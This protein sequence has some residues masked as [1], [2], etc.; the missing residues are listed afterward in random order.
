MKRSYPEGLLT[1]DLSNCGWY[2]YVTLRQTTI[3]VGPGPEFPS[4]ATVA[5]GKRMGRQSVRNPTYSSNPPLRGHR[6]GYVWCYAVQGGRT[7]WVVKS[8]LLPAEGNGRTNGP[9][10][11]DFEVGRGEPRRKARPRFVLGKPRSG[12]RTVTASEVHLRISARGTSVYYL[13]R[14][15]RVELLWRSGM[16]GFYGVEVLESKSARVGQRG[17]VKDNAIS[18]GA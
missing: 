12:V 1:R 13:Q 2:P 11:E 8:D 16:F 7:G 15:D 14:S 17:W 18:K 4:L 9:A 3:R 10:R 5:A 6:N